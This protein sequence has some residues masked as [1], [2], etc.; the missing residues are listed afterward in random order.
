MC[1]RA[2]AI[3]AAQTPRILKIRARFSREI[4]I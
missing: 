1:A 4:A 2:T 3:A